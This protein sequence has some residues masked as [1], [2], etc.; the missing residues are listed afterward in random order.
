M[1]ILDLKKIGLTEGEVKIYKALLELGECTRTSLA[2]E[3]GV[4][5]SKVYDVANRLLEKG[6]ISTVKKNQIIHFSAADPERLKDFLKEKETEI[7]KEKELVDQLLPTLLAKY[8]HTKD[9]ADVEVFYGWEGMRTVFNDILKTM[10]KGD[11]NFVFGASMG[12]DS[13]KA[14]LFFSR[15]YQ[16]IPERGFTVKIIFN[17]NVRGHEKRTGYYSS[18]PPHEVRYLHQDTFAELNLYGDTVL[19]I[20]LFKNPIIIRIRNEETSD[21][22]RNCYWKC[23]WI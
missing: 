20:L 13:D 7:T 18:T 17:E 3:S 14:D 1:D 15:Y 11:E 16:Q 2:K 22:F 23:Y 4:S 5:P 8:Q 12:Q 6:I 10:S 21:A 9:Q 19:L